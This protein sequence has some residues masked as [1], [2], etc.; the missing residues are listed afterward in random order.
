MT[1]RRRWW[2]RL[3]GGLVAFGAIEGATLLIHGDADELR[4][5]LVVALVV[6]AAALLIDASPVEPA[7]WAGHVEPEGGLG[8]LDPRTATYLRIL[9]S[10]LSAREVDG[11]LRNRLQELAE[12]TLRARHDLTVDDPRAEELLGHEL[13][14]V[15]N[16]S[17]TKLDPDQIDRCVK[18]I[19]EL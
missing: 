2:W 9:E 14:R 10:H 1:G 6:C 13:R 18:R 4:L 15:L 19:E 3:A 16:E 7:V 5:A 8:R 11:A 12:Q 17:P